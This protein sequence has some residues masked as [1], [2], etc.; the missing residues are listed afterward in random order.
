MRRSVVLLLAA[1]LLVGCGSE[2]VGSVDTTLTSYAAGL[3]QATNQYRESLTQVAAPE[4]ADAGE[5]IGGAAVT[6]WSYVAVVRSLQPPD[7]VDPAHRAYVEAL[8]GSASY[9]NDA[10]AALEGVPLE[11]M[12]EVLESRFGST[13][14]Q[15]GRNV[16]AACV[17]LERVTA[18]AGIGIQLGCES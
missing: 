3:T 18:L 17:E 4:G 13:A 10:A 8:E 12:P 7:D 2:A 16:T 5:V 14:A 15:L 6:M 1:T 9:M 11:D